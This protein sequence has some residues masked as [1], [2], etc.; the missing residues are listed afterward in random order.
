MRCPVYE[1]VSSSTVYTRVSNEP[2]FFARFIILAMAA[3]IR[4]HAV[5]A[6]ILLM[7]NYAGSSPVSM[8]LL[9]QKREL[10]GNTLLIHSPGLGSR[11]DITDHSVC[12]NVEDDGILTEIHIVKQDQRTN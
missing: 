3:F 9:A 5:S 11:F 1:L 2:Q 8:P 6:E 7:L 12:C 4:V 10:T